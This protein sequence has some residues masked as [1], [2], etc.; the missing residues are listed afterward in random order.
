VT[1]L[2][3]GA[4]RRRFL[5]ALGSPAGMTGALAGFVLFGIGDSLP[6]GL[7]GLV[8]G[9]LYGYAVVGLIRAFRVT[10]GFYWL[11]GVLCGPV[12]F[13]FLAG[14]VEKEDRGGV[15]VLTALF[16]LVVGLVEWG[17]RI[18][19]QREDPAGLER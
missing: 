3:P 17:H 1:E 5:A 14:G 6:A 10:P 4:F 18:R 7:L 15:V 8:I 19:V 13:V 9:W 12:P 2:E 16:G 11:V